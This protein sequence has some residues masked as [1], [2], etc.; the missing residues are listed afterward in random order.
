[1]VL[2]PRKK[3]EKGVPKNILLYEFVVRASYFMQLITLLRKRYSAQSLHSLI[4]EALPATFL[5]S[6]VTVV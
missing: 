4:E 3:K 1:M 2:C 5:A 6:S